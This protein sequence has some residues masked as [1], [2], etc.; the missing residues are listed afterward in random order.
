MRE[1]EG[2]DL[3]ERV[4]L[5]VSE[6]E[7]DSLLGSSGEDGLDVEVLLENLGVDAAR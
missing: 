5:V 7:D 2:E 3:V 6:G 4:S 1:D